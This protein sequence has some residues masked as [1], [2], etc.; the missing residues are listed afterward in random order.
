MPD[1]KELYE[2]NINLLRRAGLEYREVKHEPVL[3]YETAAGVRTRFGLSGT[4]SKSLFLKVKKKGYCMLI[5]LEGKR[6]D[7]NAVR[8]AL[9]SKISIANPEELT[10]NTGCIPGC[11]TPLGHAREI[12]LVVDRDILKQNKLLYS[13]G[14]PDK[15]IELDGRDIQKLLDISDNP[16]VYV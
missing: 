4:E 9:G 11:A 3:D 1:L 7:L 5:T 14:P 8:Q 16:V 6:A 15:T 12:T 10:E 2:R 13:P